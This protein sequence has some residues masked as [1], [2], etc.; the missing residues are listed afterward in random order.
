MKVDKNDLK[1]KAEALLMELD[2]ANEIIRGFMAELSRHYSLRAMARKLGVKSSGYIADVLSGR[3]RL[4]TK[5]LPNLMEA[6]HLSAAGETVLKCLVKMEGSSEEVARSLRQEI[7]RQRRLLNVKYFQADEI[8]ESV[9][10]A[11]DLFGALSLFP[12]GADRATLVKLFKPAQRPLFDGAMALLLKNDVVQLK[13]GI[14]S[15]KCQELNFKTSGTKPSYAQLMKLTVSEGMDAINTWYADA[16]RSCFAST[17]VSVKMADLP[18]KL[19]ALR[20]G[21]ERL[22]SDLED[23]TGDATIKFNVQVFPHILLSSIKP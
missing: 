3:R 7:S 11:C 9:F 12:H 5:Y 8:N 19:E 10:F 23:P 16:S 18:M 2:N 20:L 1:R 13:D 21:L 22:Y 15:Q 4:S 17:S 14:F 6:L